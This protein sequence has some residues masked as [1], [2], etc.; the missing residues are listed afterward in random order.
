M[1][2]SVAPYNVTITK[3]VSNEIPDFGLAAARFGFKK[4]FKD[5]DSSAAALGSTLLLPGFNHIHPNGG[6]AAGVTHVRLPA[7]GNDPSRLGTE[8]VVC[9]KNTGVGTLTVNAGGTDDIVLMDQTTAA[10]DTVAV[11]TTARYF[12][13]TIASANTSTAKVTWFRY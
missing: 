9:F 8:F 2:G 13:G 11:N 7:L 12:A 4:E 3:Q 6:A 10:T 1:A 5:A